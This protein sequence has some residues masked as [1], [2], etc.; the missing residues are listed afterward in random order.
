[1]T[2]PASAMLSLRRLVAHTETSGSAACTSTRRWSRLPGSI[3]TNGSKLALRRRK[4]TFSRWASSTI[5]HEATHFR[6]VLGTTDYGYGVDYCKQFALEDPE[7]AV[8][9]AE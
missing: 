7:K 3:A 6:D 5:I 8:K 1:M 9:N 2:A 4:E